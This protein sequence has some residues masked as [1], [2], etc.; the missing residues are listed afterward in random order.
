MAVFALASGIFLLRIPASLA[1]DVISY[2]SI[3]RDYA[4]GRWAEAVNGY[5]GPLTSWLLAPLLAMHM[6]DNAAVKCAAF[7]AGMA[8]FAGLMAILPRFTLSRPTRTAALAIGGLMI[9]CTMLATVP[10]LLLATALLFYLAV[11]LSPSYAS[12]TRPAVLCGVLGAVAYFTKSYGFFFFAAHFTLSN[13]LFWFRSEGP[14][15]KQAVKNASAGLAAFVI[16]SAPWIAAI[17]WKE[18]RLVLGTSGTYNYRLVGPKSLGYTSSQ[19]LLPP[20]RPHSISAWE[21]PQADL[22]PPWSPLTSASAFHHQLLLTERNAARIALYL[23]HVSPL[24]LLILPAYILCCVQRGGRWFDEWIVPVMTFFLYPA[25]YLLVS[26]EDRYLYLTAFLLLLMGSRVCDDIVGKATLSPT[27]RWGSIAVL[28][29]SFCITPVRTVAALPLRDAVAEAAE[30]L[31]ATNALHGK[32]ASCGGWNK[33][34]EIANRLGLPYYGVLGPG[35][36]GRALAAVLNPESESLAWPEE[37]ADGADRQLREKD[38]DY[39]LIWNDCAVPPSSL[40]PE[41]EVAGI[42]GLGLHIYRLKPE[43]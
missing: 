42:D 12:S 29:A 19:E 37:T 38:I 27:L 11:L 36:D 18:G 26:V 33:S 35:P 9:P 8:A 32:L 6:A 30:R 34:L 10:D 16:L 40:R 1:P 2:L 15:R 14:L 41:N 3:G 43:N 23:I 13:I 39:L 17:S 28:V 5:W 21:D 4:A 20:S 7:V 22:L 24:L 31:A 25:G